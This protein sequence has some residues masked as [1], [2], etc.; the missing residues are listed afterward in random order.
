MMLAENL[1]A[2]KIQTID[3]LFLGLGAANSLLLI[4]MHKQQLLANKKIA[5]IDPDHTALL[6]K[7][8]CFWGTQTEM[9]ELGLDDSITNAWKN[10]IVNNKSS[11]S[12]TPLEY[13]HIPGGSLYKQ[14]QTILNHYDV[15][16]ITEPYKISPEKNAD[17][18]IFTSET[19][20]LLAQTVFD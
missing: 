11:E 18:F 10:L 14:A 1:F 4:Q 7:T 6:K 8:Y 3:Y 20:V 15:K 19:Q 5:I 16:I 9:K 17:K 12:I 2:T 13:A